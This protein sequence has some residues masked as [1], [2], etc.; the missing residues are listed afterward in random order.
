MKS[1]P[2]THSIGRRFV[3][4]WE[5]VWIRVRLKVRSK[6]VDLITLPTW[7]SEISEFC[8]LVWFCFVLC[9]QN[10]P[11]FFW[12]KQNKILFIIYFGY[13]KGFKL[14]SDF[15][16][17]VKFRV[18]GRVALSNLTQFEAYVHLEWTKVNG[19][20]GPGCFEAEARSVLV[21]CG[22]ARVTVEWGTLEILPHPH[23]R[24][25]CVGTAGKSFQ[26]K[27]LTQL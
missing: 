9:K 21:L 10:N 8:G 5:S 26:T 7:R 23:L 15:G 18:K 2:K 11:S 1:L 22:V 20:C 27:E 4:G 24:P 3:N 19:P 14:P 16:F 13:L 6:W 12:R 17:D 25:Q